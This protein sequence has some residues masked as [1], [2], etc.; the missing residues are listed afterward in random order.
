MIPEELDQFYFIF[1]GRHPDDPIPP[2]ELVDADA[3]FENPYAFDV[4]TGAFSVL[5][6]TRFPDRIISNDVEDEVLFTVV[7][8]LVWLARTAIYGV[9]SG[10]FCYPAGE[11][12]LPDP[13][14]TR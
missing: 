12:N 4:L 14:R 13:E 2:E 6:I 1:T 8:D 5:S 9:A 10:Q 7:N 11:R 3:F